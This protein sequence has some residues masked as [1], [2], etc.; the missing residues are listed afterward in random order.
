[1][2]GILVMKAR[3]EFSQSVQRC[4]LHPRGFRFKTSGRNPAKNSQT[5]VHRARRQNPLLS[6][7]CSPQTGIDKKNLNSKLAEPLGAMNNAQTNLSISVFGC[8]KAAT[9]HRVVTV[10]FPQ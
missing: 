10:V 4:P 1:V 2:I 6:V 8:D 3:E 7:L 5:N 9:I